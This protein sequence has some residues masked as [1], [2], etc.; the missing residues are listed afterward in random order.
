MEKLLQE[1]TTLI[2]DRYSYSGVAFSAAKG[3]DLNWCKAPEAGLLK[4]DLVL[5]LTLNEEASKA[6]SGYGNERCEP[7]TVGN[8]DGFNFLFSFSRYETPV[9]QKKVKSIYEALQETNWQIV[10]ADKTQEKLNEELMEIV[11]K[12]MNHVETETPAL[13]W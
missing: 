11:Q 6:R 2:V 4:P 9:F 7:Q 12:T 3:L 5:F 8:E 13:L 1:G 10:D